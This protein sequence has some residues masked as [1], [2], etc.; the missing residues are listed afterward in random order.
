[1]LAGSAPPSEGHAEE[2][3][4][5][6]ASTGFDEVLQKLEALRRERLETY[7]PLIAAMR[8]DP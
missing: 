7:A 4:T 6:L 8:G 1:M 5:R 3:F 2:R